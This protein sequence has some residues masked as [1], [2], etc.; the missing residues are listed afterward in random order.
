MLRNSLTGKQKS[1][2]RSMGQKLEPVVM[3]GKEG[4]TPTVVQ[5]AQEAIK[6]RELIKVRVLQNCME[7]PEDAI[8][9]LAE[10]A[11]VNLVQII[12]RNGLLFKRNYE[13]PKIE[14]P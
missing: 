14:L 7:E 4:V 11:D 8:T 12:G 2:L 6:K 9:M 10:R 5:A 1:F 13:K 3:M